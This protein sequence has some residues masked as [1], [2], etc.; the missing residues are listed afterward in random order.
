M[1]AVSGNLFFNR[2]LAG[3]PFFLFQLSFKTIVFLYCR[4]EM[5][6]ICCPVSFSVFFFFFFSLP[7]CLK[8]LVFRRGKYRKGIRLCYALC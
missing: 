6:Y 8:Y 4:H 3:A 7:N 1:L 2:F 5:K